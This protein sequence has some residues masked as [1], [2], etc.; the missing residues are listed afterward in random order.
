MGNK[1]IIFLAPLITEIEMVSSTYSGQDTLIKMVNGACD[2]AIFDFI[3]L[4]HLKMIETN[5]K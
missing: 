2:K 1:K 4:V 3:E 5:T